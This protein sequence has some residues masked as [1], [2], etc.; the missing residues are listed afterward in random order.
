MR[1]VE[2]MIFKA[3]LPLQFAQFWN[4][5]VKGIPVELTQMTEELII[6]FST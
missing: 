6:T 5:S 4:K 3:S 2:Y 1:K